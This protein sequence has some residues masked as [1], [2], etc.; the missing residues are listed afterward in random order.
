MV[1]A[2]RS[3]HPAQ[4]RP[5]AAVKSRSLKSSGITFIV[6]NYLRV[7][8]L[9][10]IECKNKYTET[11]NKKLCR[12]GVEKGGCNFFQGVSGLEVKPCQ[13]DLR[14]PRTLR[15]ASSTKCSCTAGLIPTCA[16]AND[17]SPLLLSRSQALISGFAE[18]A[19][20]LNTHHM[21]FLP[22]LSITPGINPP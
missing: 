4:K 20:C 11:I 12:I 10:T 16:G 21:T 7:R 14:N 9:I 2:D 17:Y 3:R 22:N 18:V 5:D 19:L 8:R 15:Y 1:N 13:G 6:W